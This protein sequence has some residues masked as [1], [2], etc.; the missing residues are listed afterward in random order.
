MELFQNSL[1][2][3]NLGS[4][5]D[6]QNRLFSKTNFQKIN[7]DASFN[8]IV[9]PNVIGAAKS[10]LKSNDSAIH[11]LEMNALKKNDTNVVHNNWNFD[12]LIVTGNQ[13]IVEYKLTTE[14]ILF[15]INQFSFLDYLFRQYRFS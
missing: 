10:R 3:P 2:T 11:D 1:D 5:S 9:A 4:W 15:V 14:I 7:V 13:T 12:E 6:I 8:T